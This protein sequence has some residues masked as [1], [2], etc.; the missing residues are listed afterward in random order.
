VGVYTDCP[1]FLST[2]YYLRNGKATNFKFC[3]HILSIDRNK[4]PLQILGQVAEC[5]VRTLE[6]FQAPIY[7]A[8]RA[9]FFAIAQLSCWVCIWVSDSDVHE[10][11]QAETETRPE[12]Q[13]SETETLGILVETRPRRDPR[14]RGPRPRRDVLH[15]R[16]DRDVWYIKIIQHNKIRIN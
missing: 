3:T 4:S 16:R 10:T 1:N 5:V 2:P 14:R 9:V 13:R 7:W 15:P 11:F 12:T 8:H 6:T